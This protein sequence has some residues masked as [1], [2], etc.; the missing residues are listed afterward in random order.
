MTFNFEY[1]VVIPVYNSHEGLKELYTEIT[2]TFSEINS[3]FEV[4]FVDDF[5]TDNSWDILQEIKQENTNKNITIVKLSKNFGQHKATLCGIEL[6]NGERTITID[7][8]LQVHPKEILKLINELNNNDL[9]VVYGSYINKKHSKIKNTGSK[10]I[11][12][13]TEIPID[14]NFKASSFRLFKTELR[15]NFTFVKNKTHI[16]IDEI[17]LWNTANIGA[18]H[19]EHSERKYNTSSYSPKKL[20]KLGLNVLLFTTNIP[21]K[22]MTIFGFLGSLGSFI[23]GIRFLYRRLV[24]DVPLG[25]TSIIVTILFSTS[26]LLLMFGIIGKYINELYLS[27]NQKPPYL[28]H[29]I[30]K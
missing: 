5:S 9:D 15:K 24:F 2:N 28:I 8:D 1:S 6:T 3:S 30:V 4:I 21:L 27:I 20:F 10:L 25:Y 12:P 23:L 7:D 17:L 13:Q 22:L 26:I 16:F 14:S 18:V 19:V 29:K 11:Q